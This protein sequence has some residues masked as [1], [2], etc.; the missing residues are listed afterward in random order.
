MR[1]K[2]TTSYSTNKT[3]FFFAI[4]FLI[5]GAFFY[6][7]KIHYLYSIYLKKEIGAQLSNTDFER[8]RM[9]RI[10][11]N[12]TAYRFGIDLSHYQ[13]KEDIDWGNL[14]IGNGSIP[15]KF[16]IIRASMG[17]QRKDKHF[18]HYWNKAK[19]N[20]LV[21]GAYH[22]YRPD[23]DPVYQ[24]NSY[25]EQVKLEQGDIIPILDI[26]K[27]PS[28]KNK[29]KYISDI[30]I[31]LKIVENAYKTKPMIY[32]YA[33]FYQ[34]YLKEDFGDYPLWLANYNDVSEPSDDDWSM[35]QF[36]EKGIVKGIKTKVDLNIYRGLMWRN[37]TL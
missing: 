34:D 22:Y 5:F 28:V 15:L 4:L 26:E 21:R 19:E 18:N 2:K 6:R 33:S 30:K 27:M 23:E 1:K 14:S 24:A 12:N 7:K 32:T 3:I 20:G 36:S 29:E 16:V 37:I 8:K 13:N 25:L 31:W 35:W 10:I 11:R 17:N 9:Q